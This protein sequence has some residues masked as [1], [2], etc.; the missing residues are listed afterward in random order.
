MSN[1]KNVY[2]D[3]F[4]EKQWGLDFNTTQLICHSLSE[5]HFSV[6]GGNAVLASLFGGTNFIFGNSPE[7]KSR[8]V[9]HTNSYLSKISNTKIIGIEK[10]KDLTKTL[11]EN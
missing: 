9:C 3:K 6:A 7:G 1:F 5:K 11:N 8:L 10:T 2:T 4:L